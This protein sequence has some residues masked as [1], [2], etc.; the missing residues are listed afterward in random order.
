MTARPPIVALV[1][2]LASLGACSGQPDPAASPQGSGALPPSAGPTAA[3]SSPGSAVSPGGSGDPGSEPSSEPEPSLDARVESALSR[4][5]TDEELVGQLLMIGWTG[6]SVDA[7]RDAIGTLRPGGIVFIANASS[8][9]QAAALN[10]GLDGAAAEAGIMPL[11][12][13]IDHEGGAI[14]RIDDV[15]NLGSNLAFAETRP[16]VDQACQR[17]A[18]HARQLLEMGFEMNLAP[19]LDVNT[20]PDNP[21]IGPRSYG[22]RPQLVARL[23]SAYI[24]GLQSGGIMAVGKHF[25]GHGDTSVDSHL[26]LPVLDVGRQRLD[27]VELL[28]FQRAIATDTGLAAVMTAHIALPR[29]DPSRLPATLSKTVI[30][31][32]LRG[33]LAF[34][35]LVISD[36]L[37]AMAAITDAYAPGEAA[38]L[39]IGAGVDLLIVGGDLERQRTMR[40]ALLSALTS[41]ELARE[42]VMEAVR[43]VLEAKARAGLLGG[44]P[45]AVPGC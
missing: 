45:D 21:V 37:A 23:G 11:L 8:A 15:E 12:K 26:D 44:E 30:S 43:H 33:D 18:T 16:T 31:D 35:G 10:V 19:V 28:P 40:D 6:S 41:G 29:I 4:L 22:S 36:D 42:R 7:A 27:D 39:A 14:Q 9:D 38:A 32:I 17:G 13:A 1:L 25:P 24:R 3:P 34:D 2:L 5:V 20:N